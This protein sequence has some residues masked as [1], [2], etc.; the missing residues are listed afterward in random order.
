MARVVEATLQTQGDAGPAVSPGD[1]QPLLTAAAAL[2]P[3]QLW[4][5]VAHPRLGLGMQ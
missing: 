2:E 5:A 1:A 3:K 4:A